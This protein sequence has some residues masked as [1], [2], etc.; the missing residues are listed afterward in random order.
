MLAHDRRLGAR[1]GRS[2]STRSPRRSCSRSPFTTG[3]L[4][5]GACLALVALG[6]YVM[7]TS[8]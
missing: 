3:V 4:A 6:L 7:F 5:F 2:S 8:K 1:S